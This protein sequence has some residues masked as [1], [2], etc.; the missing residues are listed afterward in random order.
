MHVNR[1]LVYHCMLQDAGTEAPH[2]LFTQPR[3]QSG[4]TDTLSWH[5]SNFLLQNALEVVKAH[6]SIYSIRS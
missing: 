3:W 1:V 6:G 4:N 5:C 2:S